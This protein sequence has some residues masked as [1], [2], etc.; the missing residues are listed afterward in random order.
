MPIRNE[1][2]TFRVTDEHLAILRNLSVRTAMFVPEPEDMAL[3][4]PVEICPDIDKKRLFGNSGPYDECT[5]EL[6]GCKYED[7]EAGRYSEKDLYHARLLL[8]QVP[9]AYQAVMAHGV[10]E[11]CA[12]PLPMGPAW[13]QY[14]SRRALIFWHGAMADAIRNGADPDMLAELVANAGNSTP[15]DVLRDIGSFAG[16]VIWIRQAL[17]IL[18]RH[19][20]HAF[21]AGNP[22][23]A[24]ELE[25][26]V[27][28]KLISG[29]YALSYGDGYDERSDAAT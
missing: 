12:V 23:K 26:A 9:L 16:N 3:R 1:T 17:S 2:Q 20:V 11:P 15:M 27:L 7:A 25:D 22:E 5:L 19:A 4:G 13:H 8:A 18:Q 10:I 21:R 29:E 28:E 14:R 24:A 6:L